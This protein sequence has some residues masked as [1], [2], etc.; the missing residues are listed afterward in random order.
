MF[1]WHIRPRQGSIFL[2]GPE[3]RVTEEF[4]L[5]A[6]DGIIVLMAAPYVEGVE[7]VALSGRYLHEHVSPAVEVDFVR[8]SALAGGIHDLREAVGLEGVEFARATALFDGVYHDGVVGNGVVEESVA[9]VV[10]RIGLFGITDVGE[11]GVALRE[12]REV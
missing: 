8:V 6:V 2:N 11:Q 4:S 12:E 9:F 3:G 5:G 7:Q 1:V 10:E